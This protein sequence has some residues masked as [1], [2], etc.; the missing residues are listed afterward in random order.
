MSKP[1]AAGGGGGGGAACPSSGM[2]E[3]NGNFDSNNPAAGYKFQPNFKRVRMINER[4]QGTLSGGPGQIESVRRELLAQVVTTPGVKAQAMVILGEMLESMPL[5]SGAIDDAQITQAHED[6]FTELMIDVPL[7]TAV[8]S[9]GNLFLSLYYRNNPLRIATA[10]AAGA[11]AGYVAWEGG[12]GRVAHL[13]VGAGS[14]LLAALMTGYGYVIAPGAVPLGP[15]PQQGVPQPQ[16]GVPQGPLPFNVSNFEEYWGVNMDQPNILPA[17]RVI[18]NDIRSGLIAELKNPRN[19]AYAVADLSCRLV[20]TIFPAGRDFHPL[21]RFNMQPPAPGLESPFNTFIRTIRDGAA[22]FLNYLLGLL[23]VVRKVPYQRAGVVGPEDQSISYNMRIKMTDLIANLFAS[24]RAQGV[25]TGMIDEKFMELYLSSLINMIFPSEMLFSA[26]IGNNYEA[27]KQL[28]FLIHKIRDRVI[29]RWTARGDAYTE[30]ILLQIFPCFRGRL[31]ELALQ[32]F[33]SG[34]PLA[35]VYEVRDASGSESQTAVDGDS[36]KQD[37]R[38]ASVQHDWFKQCSLGNAHVFSSETDQ[39][40]AMTDEEWKLTGLMFRPEALLK[41][42]ASSVL[43]CAA[44]ELGVTTHQQVLNLVE[45]VAKNR[46]LPI[47]HDFPP[48]VLMFLSNIQAVLK[49]IQ[50]IVDKENPQEETTN[51]IME[52][53]KQFGDPRLVSDYVKSIVTLSRVWSSGINKDIFTLAVKTPKDGGQEYPVV[54]LNLESIP[55]YTVGAGGKILKVEIPTALLSGFAARCV[56]TLGNGASQLLKRGWGLFCGGGDVKPAKSELVPAKSELVL[57]PVVAVARGG[58]DT[59]LKDN[60]AKC[61]ELAAAVVE[62]PFIDL[63]PE[64]IPEL[65]AAVAAD[66]EAAVQEAEEAK[67]QVDAQIAAADDLPPPLIPIND[68][69]MVVDAP[70]IDAKRL[71][72]DQQLAAAAAASAAEQQRIDDAAKS[73]EQRESGKSNL[74]HGGG[75]SRRKSRKNSKKTTRRNKGR[76]ASKTAKKTQQLRARRSSRHRRSSRNGRK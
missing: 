5:G 37:E 12:I 63:I 42:A 14:T 33:V 24:F 32:T 28:L 23:D 60:I 22:G 57:R 31:T 25:A 3:L 15:Q 47:A 20:D 41:R 70:P 46:A 10:A 6:V 16:Q 54:I 4:V 44:V 7:T 74:P 76:K 38:L 30:E 36:Q 29:T 49:V 67:Q 13:S 43:P 73:E 71:E 9:V 21:Q 8:T 51:E 1:R 11:A 61:D 17:D 2:A 35:C 56:T 69:P 50:G 66:A 40:K 39:F 68:K 72:A 53:Y 48:D 55:G 65:E 58:G 64:L 19:I 75:K 27:R 45:N 62:Q 52:A 26:R 59:N 18:I 34:D